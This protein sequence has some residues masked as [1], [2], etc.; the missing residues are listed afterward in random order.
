[1]S[2]VAVQLG[3]PPLTRWQTTWRNLVAVA[4]GGFV[5]AFVAD[6][7]W[8]K[9][10]YLVA[11][12][13]GLGVVTLLAMNFRRRWPL[14]MALVGAVA[15]VASASSSGAG[16]IAFISMSTR[17]RWA[18]MLPVAATAV[19]AGQLYYEFEPRQ[20][21]SG[22]WYVSLVLSIGFAGIAIAIGMYIGARRE[23][24]ATLED[25]AVRAEREQS[26]QVA[27]AQAHERN[28]IAREMHD[29]LAHR[30]SLVAMH[31]GALAYR[32]NLT[33]QETRDAAEIIQA[34]SHRALT[35]LREILGVLRDEELDGAP[36]RPQ[37]TLYDLGELIADERASGA[38][39]S[40]KNS[41]SL[42]DEVPDSIGRTAYRVV[43]EGLTNARKH[44]PNTQV[45]VIVAGRAGDGLTVEVRN[46]TRVGA[47]TTTTPGAGLGLVGL[48]ER[49]ALA[50]GRFEQGR[51][52]EG[53]FVVRAW[54][55][56]A[57]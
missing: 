33:E 51:T 48:A 53:D 36:N 11:L 29:V 47:A 28:R 24:L 55:P 2:T 6:A 8:D 12:D 14:A 37:P 13:L 32:H 31:A 16:V 46:P 43:Q 22:P 18:E 45:D 38:R 7:Q 44:A 19:V 27:Q 10:A 26:L 35:D 5:W 21:D 25:R 57:A 49:A 30:M 23:L 41:L 1:V 52:L 54:L 34:N 3:P 4:F 20:S 39:I 56:W 50:H 40:L 17:R 42:D 9:S 15:G